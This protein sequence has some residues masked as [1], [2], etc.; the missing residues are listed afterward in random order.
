MIAGGGIGEGEVGRVAESVGAGIG[1]LV[2]F[3]NKDIVSV[4]VLLNQLAKWGRG[5]GMNLE[6]TGTA[7]PRRAF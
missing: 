7:F 5:G 3:L 4:R 6:Q 2:C 1:F